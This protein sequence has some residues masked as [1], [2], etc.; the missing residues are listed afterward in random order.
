MYTISAEAAIDGDLTTIWRVVTDVANWP[1]WDPHEEAARL[2][3][4]FA[5]GTTGWSKPRGG[6]A[7][8]WTITEVVERRKWSSECPLPGGKLSGDNTFEQVGD[9]VLCRKTVHVRGPLTPLFRFYFG[10]KIRADM[11][12]TFAALEKAAA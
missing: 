2:D 11:L 9:K 8:D 1:A 6:P 4:P 5:A 12:K 7:T 3:G 10:R